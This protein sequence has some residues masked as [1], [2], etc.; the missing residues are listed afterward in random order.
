MPAARLRPGELHMY[1][2]TA[3]ASFPHATRLLSLESPRQSQELATHCPHLP[4]RLLL[5][6]R[7]LRRQLRVGAAHAAHL[8]VH[9]GRLLPCPLA[10]ES[11]RTARQEEV[12]GIA[13][14]HTAV[15]AAARRACRGGVPERVEPGAATDSATPPPLVLAYIVSGR[16]GVGGSLAG[17]E[18]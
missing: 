7:Q 4:L 6:L 11:P 8:C 1:S 14:G 12:A 18:R 17:Y 16:A 10:L 5:H 13:G 9:V 3:A 15:A 2:S